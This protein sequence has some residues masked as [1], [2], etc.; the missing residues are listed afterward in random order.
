MKTVFLVFYWLNFEKC[1]GIDSPWNSKEI[2]FSM[3][4]IVHCPM[5]LPD[6]I[7]AAFTDLSKFSMSIGECFRFKQNFEIDGLA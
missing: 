6:V 5:Q 7:P 3:K 4:R 2:L 1:D